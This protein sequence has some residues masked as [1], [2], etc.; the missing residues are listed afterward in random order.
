MNIEDV[1]KQREK[2]TKSEVAK[3]QA[4][5]WFNTVAKSLACSSPNQL[6]KL[7]Q[8]ESIKKDLDGNNVSTKA[9]HRY[10]NGTRLPSDGFRPNGIAGPV[11]AA[12]KWSL[13]SLTIYR[14]PIW[15]IMR[16]EKFEFRDTVKLLDYFDP[17]VR[18]YYIDLESKDQNDIFESFVQNVGLPIWID[19]DDDM[20][21]SLDHLCINL[22]ILRMDMFAYDKNVLKGVVENIAK[23]LGPLSVSPWIEPIYEEMYD[24]LENNVWKDIFDKYYFENSQSIKG[25]RK[26]RWQW[27]YPNY[28]L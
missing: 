1:K 16:N 27:I 9:W 19:R 23:T 4:I 5:S 28:R 6:E 7:I 18:R 22:M 25:W 26:S 10:R 20:I 2:S 3:F 15:N 12:G 8:P 24:W 14:H 13:N 21:R 11:V 17:F